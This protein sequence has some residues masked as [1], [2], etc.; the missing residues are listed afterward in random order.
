MTRP[1]LM[2]TKVMDDAADAVRPRFRNRGVVLDPTDAD[3]RAEFQI[4]DAVDQR[5]RQRES[6]VLPLA[7]ATVP[8]Y[9]VQQDQRLV[10]RKRADRILQQEL[11][12]VGRQASQW[13]RRPLAL[14]GKQRQAAPFIE[15]L[16]RQSCAHRRHDG[17]GIVFQLG[18]SGRPIDLH[19]AGEMRHGVRLDPDAPDPAFLALD[20]RRARAAERVE[21]RM[22]R[23]EAEPFQIVRDQVG[24]ER[25]H[26]PVPFMD[27]PV[28]GPQLVP[29][30]ARD[31]RVW[32]GLGWHGRRAGNPSGFGG[33]STKRELPTR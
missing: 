11:R 1:T 31:G 9:G 14:R 23:T 5:V 28:L 3:F 15:P 32:S 16:F 30:G 18:G 19:R 6:A 24:R 20:Q 2:K 8:V 25:Q 27:R 4:A 29:V 33:Q 22:G 26:E 10:Q 17:F 21:H 12:L 7:A 13:K